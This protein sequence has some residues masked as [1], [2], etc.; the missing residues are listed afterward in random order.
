MLHGK[1]ARNPCKKC[2]SA[3]LHLSPCLM[4]A[5]MLICRWPPLVK[6][7]TCPKLCLMRISPLTM[8][9][10]A[11]IWKCLMSSGVAWR[12]IRAHSQGKL[13]NYAQRCQMMSSTMNGVEVWSR[14]ARGQPRPG[15]LR[16]VAQCRCSTAGVIVIVQSRVLVMVGC[17]TH[18]SSG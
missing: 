5:I 1:L 16:R 13:P 11:S 14:W 7:R 10:I 12:W 9:Q 15:R 4:L 17:V 2:P 6:S 18:A 3:L 8:R